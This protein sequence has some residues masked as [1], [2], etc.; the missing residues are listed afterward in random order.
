MAQRGGWV[1]GL[2][3][4]G[5][6]RRRQ[7]GECGAA[8]AGYYGFSAKRDLLM[9]FQTSEQLIDWLENTGRR[10]NRALDIVA[11]LFVAL[12]GFVPKRLRGAFE[13]LVGKH[14]AMRGQVIEQAGAVA[15]KQWQVILNPM[16]AGAMP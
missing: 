1:V 7:R 5:Q 8:G 4:D 12:A 3:V 10:Q 15:E 13:P 6:G 11:A 16:P 9:G 14:H 2:G